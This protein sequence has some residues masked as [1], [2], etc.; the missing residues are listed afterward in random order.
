MVT[1]LFAVMMAFLRFLKIATFKVADA[2]NIWM[3]EGEKDYVE[4]FDEGPN[5][6]RI[7]AMPPGMAAVDASIAEC[8]EDALSVG[9]TDETLIRLLEE[10]ARLGP[11]A[12]LS[13]DGGGGPG[14]GGPGGGGF[15]GGGADG[16]SGFPGGVGGLSGSAVLPSGLGGFPGGGAGMPGG[17]GGFPGSGGF[18]GGG[19]GGGADS[20]VAFADFMNAFR[21]EMQE[22]REKK[23]N[24]QKFVPS[25]SKA[26][27]AGSLGFDSGVGIASGLREVD[28]DEE[29]EEDTF[30]WPQE[31][32]TLG[33]GADGVEAGTGSS[34]SS[35]S[36]S[37]STTED[38][39][40]DEWPEEML[41]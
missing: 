33:L 29:E 10:A 21:A 26:T 24:L 39:D 14:P 8:V 5:A 13:V 28:V 12:G 9:H 35:T 31:L 38:S 34:T 7:G 17:I 36:P 27:A 22:S 6:R 15:P 30:E 37:T 40:E 25:R 19:G 41:L 16:G 4:E 3:V 11:N 2:F 1:P 18:P 23:G 32:L 20:E